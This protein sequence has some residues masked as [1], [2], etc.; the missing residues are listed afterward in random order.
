MAL[1]LA[2]MALALLVSAGSEDVLA[3][4]R[5]DGA[6][7]IGTVDKVREV[8]DDEGVGI[9]ED[10]LA[11]D[12]NDLAKEVDDD[13][14]PETD[15]DDDAGIRNGCR[16]EGACDELESVPMT[17]ASSLAMAFMET[18]CVSVEVWGPD[19]CSGSLVD[20]AEGG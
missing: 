13:G 7:N 1:L 4:L 17:G 6:S 14:L 12:G 3:G 11:D 9:K 18:F 10:N 20:V 5:L 16:F 19:C 8:D 2:L 15:V